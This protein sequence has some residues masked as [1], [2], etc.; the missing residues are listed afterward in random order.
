MTVHA[1]RNR[2]FR[3]GPVSFRWSPRILGVTLTASALAAGL[4]L[5]SLGTGDIAL[6]P[7]R[8]IEVLA[9]GG[10]SQERLVVVTLRLSRAVL[11]ILVGAMLALSGAIVQTTT[12]N[13]LASPDLLGVT[14]GAGAA[15]VAVIVLGG[16]GQAT[17]MSSLLHGLG[18]SAAALVGGLSAAALV[19]TILRIAAG[20]VLQ[21]L[22][23]GVGASALFSGLT[24]WLLVVASIDDAERAN[25]WLAG[26]LNGRG[27]VEVI[28]AATALSLVGAVLVPLSTRLPSL[29]LGTDLAYALGQHVRQ[30]RGTLLLCSV[31]LAS[32]AA[33]VAG[34]IGFVALVAPHIAQRATSA[35][36]PPLLTSAMIGALLVSASD[37]AARTVAAPLLLPTGSITAL[38]GAPFLIWLLVRQRKETVR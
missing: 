30:T 11:G 12:R 18:T 19:G 21:M 27:E 31:V 5:V 3:S 16:S 4:G 1:S 26:S 2:A 38:V 9:G 32:I 8:V 22:L 23:I 29:H 6:S 10:T 36:R 25:A 24:S 37:L 15:A 33:A 13:G 7:T 34:P 20:G 17:G 28:M 35:P 14:S